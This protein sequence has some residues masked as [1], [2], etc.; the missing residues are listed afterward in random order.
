MPSKS[1][2]RCRKAL[3]DKRKLEAVE[4]IWASLTRLAPFEGVSRMMVTINFDEAAKRTPHE[5][6]LRK[7][8]NMFAKPSL[9]D[10]LDKEH[11][12][13]QRRTSQ[14]SK[15]NSPPDSLVLVRLDRNCPCQLCQGAL[16][17]RVHAFGL[18]NVGS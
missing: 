18:R 4:R 17:M 10:S 11:P 14:R 16:R 13:I 8:F 2:L 12:A 5:P 9:V 7:V 3:L 6:K 15:P 1:D